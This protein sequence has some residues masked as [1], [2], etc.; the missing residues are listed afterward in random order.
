MQQRYVKGKGVAK[1]GHGRSTGKS[2]EKTEEHEYNIISEK[3]RKNLL[4]PA[5]IFVGSIA[6]FYLGTQS[7]R[8]TYYP[9]GMTQQSQQQLTE[10]VGG[11]QP[12]QQNQKM[13]I[14]KSISNGILNKALNSYTNGNYPDTVDNFKRL[15]I[16]LG[17]DDEWK[18]YTKYYKIHQDAI[19]RA[20][21]DSQRLEEEMYIANQAYNSDNLAEFLDESKKRDYPYNRDFMTEST[22]ELISDKTYSI[23]ANENMSEETKRKALKTLEKNMGSEFA[24]YAL[25][26]TMLGRNPKTGNSQF[27]GDILKDLNNGNLAIDYINHPLIFAFDKFWKYY[28]AKTLASDVFIPETDANGNYYKY[29]YRG[30]VIAHESPYNDS[31]GNRV[32]PDKLSRDRFGNVIPS[33]SISAYPQPDLYRPEYDISRQ[34]ITSPGGYQDIR[35]VDLLGEG[36]RVR[37]QQEQDA[38]QKMLQPDK[39]HPFSQSARDSL[40]KAG[41]ATKNAVDGLSKTIQGIL[42]PP[43]KK[44]KDG[45]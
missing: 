25:E 22:E 45:G 40:N 32:S 28:S 31:S 43:E 18:M 33:K 26:N 20:G 7:S 27:T 13:L 14:E 29:G 37:Q 39:N 21:F 35:T 30:S 12:Q 11:A 16:S 38:Q 17:V 15:I 2:Y 41:Q 8:K 44:K 9:T 10:H 5:V 34:R 3:P 24:R 23:L 4:W 42:K 1:S 36:A 6:A 19:N